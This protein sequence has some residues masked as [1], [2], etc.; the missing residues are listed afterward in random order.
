M[1]SYH[2]ARAVFSLFSG[3]AWTVIL[4]GILAV[5]LGIARGR[6]IN[7]YNPDLGAAVVAIPGVLA[8]VFGLVML[9]MAQMGRAGVDTAEYSQQMLQASRD[10]MEVSRQLVRQGEK[11]EQGYA[12]LAA[13]LSIPPSVSYDGRIST[14]EASSSAAP[15]A[16]PLSATGEGTTQKVGYSDR[17]QIEQGIPM[18]TLQG[19]DAK[20]TASS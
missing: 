9:V 18:T 20:S 11:L 10:H 2:A 1:R 5:F 6:S 15:A 14:A 3:L 16:T 8:V 4:I 19:A 17:L 13:K 7:P 12:A